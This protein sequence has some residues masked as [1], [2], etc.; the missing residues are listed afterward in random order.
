MHAISSKA[1]R[2]T[3]LGFT[4]IELLVV[5]AIIA[6]LAA[7]LLP[8]LGKA[9]TKAQGIHCM[10]NLHQLTVAWILYG[11]DFNDK[12]PPNGGI[13]SIALSMTDANI[14]NGNWVHG[15]MGTAYGAN[16]TSNA[17][18]N[19]V[20]AGSLFPYSKSVSIYK[21]P[22]D[23][24]T[25]P[26]LS[27]QAP[28]SRSMSMNFSMNPVSVWSSSLMIYR[29]QTDIIRP[30]PVDCWVFIDESPGTI[31]DGFFVCD[32]AS[33]PT[34]WVDIP[35]SYHN[36]AGGLSFADGH[37]AIKKWRDPAVLAQNSVPF[38]AAGQTPPT[39][40]KWLQDR[41]TALK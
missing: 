6:I 5:I 10:N 7:M 29:K 17:D 22:A 21:C 14:N 9:K 12:L 32:P 41:S 20:K 37:S 28:T 26:Y 33:Y 30:T 27:T 19:L 8:A 2:N 13:G 25:V 11:G 31:N 34:T 36:G 16:P 24:K 4:L 35:A 18:P 38:T 1:N 15:V 40:L 39:D 23:K 3:H